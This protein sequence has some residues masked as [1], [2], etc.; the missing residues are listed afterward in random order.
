MVSG[1]GVCLPG[2]EG[3][4]CAPCTNTNTCNGSATCYLGRC[5]EP[6]NV[7]L[8]NTCSTCV[9]SQTNG[10]GVCGCP[11]QI[12]PANGPCGTMPE[13]HSCQSGTKCIQGTCRTRCDPMLQNCP[14]S[15]TCRDFNGV[16]YCQ[17]E[18]IST[19]G[20]GGTTGGG[21]G[22]R[23]GGGGTAS[24]GGG[25]TGGGTMDLGCGCGASGGPVGLLV[26]GLI[27]LLRR[28]ARRE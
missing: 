8:A 1:I 17:D 7:N 16:F 23:G 14:L 15:S 21:G 4:V 2:T 10:A 24:G 11:D 28:R 27:G 6:C 13:V 22:S 25:G 3:S 9:Q 19:G 12:S 26:F 5:Y 18:I 20:G